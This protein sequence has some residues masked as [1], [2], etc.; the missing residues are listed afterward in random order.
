M[1]RSNLADVQVIYQT[2]TERARAATAAKRAALA[3]TPAQ[4]GEKDADAPR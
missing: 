4:E 2:S 3:T 1:T